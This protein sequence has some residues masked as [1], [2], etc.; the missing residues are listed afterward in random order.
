MNATPIQAVGIDVGGT[1]LVAA[2]IAH[3]GSIVERARRVSPAG[4]AEALLDL[5]AALA[6]ELGPGAPVGIGVAGIVDRGG[7]LVYAPNLDLVDLPMG[8]A[9]EERL[10]RRPVVLNDAS[11]AV[12]AESRLGAAAG[13]RDV[14]L[15]TLGTGVGGGLVV[16]G[17]V[18]EGANGFAT[19]L[20]HLIVHE[21]GRRCP[22]G[23]L[24]CLEAYASGTAIGVL[25]R[26]RVE[27]GV[28]TTLADVDPI[29]G[30]AV[31]AAAQAGDQVARD[32]L[33]EMGHWLGVGLAGLVNALDPEV[34]VIGGGAAS[35]TA[36]YVLPAATASMSARV[37]GTPRRKPPSIVLAQLGDDAGMLGAALVA[38]ER[39]G[40]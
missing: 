24:G 19:E 17:S 38:V 35:H 8:P 26:E 14:V 11:A 22:C 4:D 6:E 15:L 12:V 18:V 34:V 31:S 39:E 29:D 27:S 40:P 25:G 13:S 3:D 33:T 16:D 20:G 5:I 7:V 37:I 9:L 28:S 21:G 23:N 1:K 32:V 10:G 30:K 2:A 36:G